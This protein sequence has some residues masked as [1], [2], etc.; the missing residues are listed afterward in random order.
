MEELVVYSQDNSVRLGHYGYGAEAAFDDLICAPLANGDADVVVTSVQQLLGCLNEVKILT[1]ITEERLAI[2]PD[3]PTMNELV[4]GMTTTLWN[5][6]FVPAG[7]PQDVRDLL[8]D[9]AHAVV[10]SGAAQD[11]RENTG[12]L[13]YWT[14]AEEAAANIAGDTRDLLAIRE[15]MGLN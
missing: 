2:T 6:L 13:I 10:S 14:G 1:T 3:T 11:L 4:P 15:A 12:A 9:V 5:G 7:T 8:A